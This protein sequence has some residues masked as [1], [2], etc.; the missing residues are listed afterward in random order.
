MSRVALPQYLE[1]AAV[2]AELQS[3]ILGLAEVSVDISKSLAKGA[4][5]GVLG[6]AGAENVQGEDQ[7][8]LDV[9]ANDMIKDALAALPA[10]RGLASEE[11]AEVVPCH[12]AGSYLVTFV[13]AVGHVGVKHRQWCGDVY[14]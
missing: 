3:V 7:K 5:A 9:I 8:K 12:T 2:A 1:N 13:R 4:L 6:A 11:E 10:V 14:P